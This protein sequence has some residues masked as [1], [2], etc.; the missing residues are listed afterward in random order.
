MVTSKDHDITSFKFLTIF[1]KY[2]PFGY[3]QGNIFLVAQ[4]ERLW[5]QQILRILNLRLME[6]LSLGDLLH[7][8]KEPFLN[9]NLNTAWSQ[10]K[11][12]SIFIKSLVGRFSM[13]MTLPLVSTKCWFALAEISI[14]FQKHP[15][16]PSFPLIRLTSILAIPVSTLTS[17]LG[18]LN[19]K[20][21][22]SKYFYWFLFQISFSTCDNKFQ[23]KKNRKFHAEIRDRKKN[24]ENNYATS[25]RR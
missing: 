18:R 17:I 11:L 23:K 16:L 7:R 6:L 4:W 15:T 3:F 21:P 2:F 22:G 9:T 5:I 8:R 1:F 10:N 12:N 25:R 24:S 19:V 13:R 20:Q 14:V